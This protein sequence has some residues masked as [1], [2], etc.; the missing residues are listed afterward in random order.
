MSQTLRQKVDRFLEALMQNIINLIP[1]SAKVMSTS[2]IIAMRFIIQN[3]HSQR[4]VPIITSNINSKS[5]EIR[6]QCCEFLDQLLHTYPTHTLVS[7][8]QHDELESNL[9]KIHHTNGIW[10]L[11]AIVMYFHLP[12][13]KKSVFVAPVRKI[14]K[15]CFRK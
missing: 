11:E 2:G 4:F 15:P 10:G 7:T 12:I 13:F 8:P 14:T 5:R 6:R 9:K 1:N 3:T